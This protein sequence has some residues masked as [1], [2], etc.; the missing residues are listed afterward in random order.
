MR[1]ADAGFVCSVGSAQCG[2]LVIADRCLVP[3]IAVELYSC[4]SIAGH[5]LTVSK[6]RLAH[7]TSPAVPISI[8]GGLKLV[9]SAYLNSVSRRFNT[10]LVINA[11]C[12][13]YDLMC[14]FPSYGLV[15]F[16]IAILKMFWSNFSLRTNWWGVVSIILRRYS[17]LTNMHALMV[18]QWSMS[19]GLVA[20][21]SMLVLIECLREVQAPLDRISHFAA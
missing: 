19:S 12:A 8:S 9:R 14:F 7:A 17:C 6:R 21:C 4:V 10:Y 3:V 16:A 2:S 15:I 1:W 18:S 13:P 20:L 11:Q 5:V